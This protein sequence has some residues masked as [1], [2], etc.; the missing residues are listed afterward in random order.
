MGAAAMLKREKWEAYDASPPD[1]ETEMPVILVEAGRLHEI[2]TEGEAALINAGA[3]FYI[4]GEQIVRPVAEEVDA[5]RGGKT[6]TARLAPV[7]EAVLLDHLSRAARWEKLDVRS[8]KSIPS[9]PPRNI[10]AIIISRDG[11]WTFRPLAGVITTQT[12]RPDGSVLIQP[13]YDPATR[14]LLLNPPPMPALLERPTRDDA[15]AALALLEELLV[16]FPL[17]DEGSRSVALSALITPVIRGA[18]PVVPLHAN[19]APAAGSGKSYL[20]DLASGIA[21][22]Q[23]CPVIAAG[24]SEEETEKRLGAAMLKGFPLISIDNLNGELGGDALCQMIERP[25]VAIRVLG[26][27]KVLT[28]ENRATIFATGNNMQ[29][30][31]D[32]LRRVLMCTLDP[33]LERPELRVF[34]GNPF[35]T[36]LADRGKYIAAAMTIVRAFLN[37][38]ADPMPALASFEKWSRMVRSSLVWL[39]KA[40]PVSTMKS[41]R[42]EDPEILTLGA[43]MSA[44]QCA[45]GFNNPITTGDLKK[46]AEETETTGSGDYHDRGERRLVH[47]DLHQALLDAVGWKGTIDP[48][49]LGRFLAR[50]K[51]RIIGGVKLIAPEDRHLKQKRWALVR[52]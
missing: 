32:V 26:L 5:A 49:R 3:P 39:G 42:A 29:P 45:A 23:R 19:R 15:L 46:L 13:G 8:K 18:L 2:A 28:V 9:D 25:R 31:G 21:T 40:D 6:T 10:P 24:R 1:D 20:V 16:D 51:D 38:G 11:E 36:V 22:G 43:I 50:H 35:A 34:A 41:A 33:N 52:L 4:W 17:V 7:T 14:L 47:P 12:M 27:S 48:V 37:S 30:T 44:W